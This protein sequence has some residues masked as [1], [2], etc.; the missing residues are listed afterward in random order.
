MTDIKHY[1]DK[2]GERILTE[3][4]ALKTSS[5]PLRRDRPEV[6]LC[7]GCAEELSTTWLAP[8][9]SIKPGPE[10]RAA[11]AETSAKADTPR[12]AGPRGDGREARPR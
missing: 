7:R 11:K 12:K 1:C 6:E 2:C 10:R 4:S 8:V 3:R 5:G 9:G